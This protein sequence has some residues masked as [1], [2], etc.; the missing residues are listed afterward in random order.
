MVPAVGQ[1]AR[2]RLAALAVIAVMGGVPLVTGTDS[3]PLSTFPM[4]AAPRSRTESVD[5]ATVVTASGEMQRLAPR[6]LAGT[7]E[8]ILAGVTVSNAIA[9][10]TAGRLCADIAGRVSGAE[11]A[12][13][14]GTVEVVTETYDAVRWFEGDRDPIRRRTHARCPV[15]PGSP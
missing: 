5:T 9:G 6:L 10:G 8:V 1:P 11:P 3:F 15:G 7:D 13:R 4:F 2:A 12:W 14:G